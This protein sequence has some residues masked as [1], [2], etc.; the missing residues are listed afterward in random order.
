MEKKPN[1]SFGQRV[2]LESLWIICRGF[3]LLPHWVRYH[4]LGNFV[5]VLLCYVLRY[6]RRVIM[7]NLRNSFPDKSENELNRICVKSYKNLAEQIIG[8]LSQAGVSDKTMIERMKVL[9]VEQTEQSING[10][11][12]IFMTAHFGSWE[13]CIMMGLVFPT[14][15]IVGVYHELRNKVM[16]E[17]MKR[18]RRRRNSALVDI[19]ATMRYFIHNKDKKPLIMG[20]ISDQNPS[21]DIYPTTHWHKFLHQW[22]VFYN[23]AEVLAL[24]FKLPVYYFSLN[25]LKAGHYEGEFIEIYD[26]V[27]QVEPSVIMERYVRLLE[28]D[29]LREPH[30]WMWSHRRWKHTPPQELLSQKI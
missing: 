17:L 19:K 30:L 12:G 26:G 11:N 3:A 16:D 4:V 20:L 14:H 27:E 5:F 8:T 7:M 6:R 9:N 25:R 28:K 21:I 18:I 29:I 1:L 22:S 15:E 10:R 2:A 23:G 24:K 13:A